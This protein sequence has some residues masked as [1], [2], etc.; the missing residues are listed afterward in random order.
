MTNPNNT[1]LERAL[2]LIPFIFTLTVLLWLPVREGGI[3]STEIWLTIAGFCVGPLYLM[4]FYAFEKRSSPNIALLG[5]VIVSSPVVIAVS[6]IFGYELLSYFAIGLFWG[7][8]V[9][10]LAHSLYEERV[11]RRDQ[12]TDSEPATE[13]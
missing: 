1:T 3:T 5:I 12:P 13:N 8:L 10:G 11:D 6:R 7:V 4:V 2:W 9:V